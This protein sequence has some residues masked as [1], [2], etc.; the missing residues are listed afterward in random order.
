MVRRKAPKLF[1]AFSVVFRGNMCVCVCVPYRELMLYLVPLPGS[2]QRE[3]FEIFL[4]LLKNKAVSYGK[5]WV[6]VACT[7]LMFDTNALVTAL[8]TISY[9]LLTWH[10]HPDTTMDSPCEENPWASAL[11][12]WTCSSQ[13]DSSS[14]MLYEQCVAKH[15]TSSQDKWDEIL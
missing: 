4:A 13:L 15:I 10:R 5:P 11:I 3:S 1:L 7:H 8:H 9:Y 6:L 12:P 2:L 14:C